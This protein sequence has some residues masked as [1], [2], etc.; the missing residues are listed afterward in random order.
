MNKVFD[1]KF[2]LSTV[3]EIISYLPVTLEI[4]FISGIIALILGFAIAL[5]RYFN[6]KILSGI[7]KVYISFIRGTPEMVQLLLAYYGLPIFLRTLNEEFGLGLS[8]NGI[9]AIVFAVI[10]LA[11]NSAAF[12][13]ETIRS[14]MLAVDPGQIEACYSLNMTTAQAMR[15]VVFPQAFAIAL[16]PLGKKNP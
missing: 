7:C 2:M 13:S 14:A 11:L 15:K 10:A 12:M 8:V 1:V 4:A 3:P 16:P 6:V 9:P 5:V